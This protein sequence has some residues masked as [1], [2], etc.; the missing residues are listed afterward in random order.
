MVA[1]AVPSVVKLRA[2]DAYDSFTH[3]IVG[4]LH[5]LVMAF[6]TP[7]TFAVELA[8]GFLHISFSL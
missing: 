3:M 2:T 6:A 8:V 7:S 1:F 5:N 4:Y